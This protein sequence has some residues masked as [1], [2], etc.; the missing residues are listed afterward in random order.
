MLEQ[1]L[2]PNKL[3]IEYVE[4]LDMFMNEYM[5][6]KDKKREYII[7]N[8]LEMYKFSNYDIEAFEIEFSYAQRKYNG[9]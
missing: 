8:L 4:V 6:F 2:E 9:I 5:K 3:P 7:K 1:K